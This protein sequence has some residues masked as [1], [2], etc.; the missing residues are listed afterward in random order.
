MTMDWQGAGQIEAVFGSLIAQEINRHTVER[1]AQALPVPNSVFS[2]LADKG[3]FRNYLPKH[4]G[5][6]GIGIAQWGSMLEQVGYLSTDV[7]FPFLISVRMS[8]IL[9]LIKVGAHERVGPSIDQLLN[10]AAFGAFAYTENAD[11][12]SF[13]STARYDAHTRTYVLNARKPYVTGGLTAD[14]FAVFVASDSRDLQVFLVERNDPGVST[15]PMQ[16]GGV[17]SLGTALVKL[18]NVVLDEQRLLVQTDGLAAAQRHFLNC[19]RSLQAC[20]FLGRARAVI[21]DTLGYLQQTVRYQTCLAD[22]QHVQAVIGEMYIAL[23]TA[24]SAV[25]RAL[26]RQDNEQFDVDWDVIASAAKYC[27]VESINQIALSALKLTGGWG[28]T[29]D[30][31]LGRAHRDFMSLFAGADPQEKLKVDLGVRMIHE[32]E[33]LNQQ[34]KYQEGR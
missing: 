3:L 21:E 2:A 29:A 34:R 23:E 17:R 6:Q 18:D 19:R 12:F 10:G 9:F 32:F 1:D 15:T 24:R 11:A 4:Y 25:F 8:F 31:G 5:G 33:L 27:A 13:Q 7:A 28:Y 26:E 20:Q 16:L 22:M 14:L 30:S